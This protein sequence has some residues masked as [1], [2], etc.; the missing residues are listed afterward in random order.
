MTNDSELFPPRWKWEAKGYRPDEYGHWLL[1]NWQPYD[2][3]RNIL[4]RPKDLILSADGA[5]GFRLRK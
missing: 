4:R 5:A 2:G 1:G 3:P